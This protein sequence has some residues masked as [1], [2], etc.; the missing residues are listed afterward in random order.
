MDI[1]AINILEAEKDMSSDKGSTICAKK[2]EYKQMHNKTY[3]N[4]M[5]KCQRKNPK[6]YKRGDKGKL[7]ISHRGFLEQYN[8]SFKLLRKSNVQPRILYPAR[9]PSEED[10]SQDCSDVQ[11]LL[12][13]HL[14]ERMC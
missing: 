7:T 12:I 14:T 13:S 11:G 2:D 5:A 8:N 9:L 6:I 1:M 3:F 4:E 10:K